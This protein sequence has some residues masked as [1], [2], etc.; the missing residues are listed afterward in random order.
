MAFYLEGMTYMALADKSASAD[1]LDKAIATFRS[2]AETAKSAE[3]KCRGLLGVAAVQVNQAWI[4]DN[5][6]DY[7]SAADT[8]EQVLRL[9]P[10]DSYLAAEAKLGLARVHVAQGNPEKA[11]PLYQEV[12]ALRPKPERPAPPPTDTADMQRRY[13]RQTVAMLLDRHSYA[14]LAQQELDNILPPSAAELGVEIPGAGAQATP[15]KDAA[16]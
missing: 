6:N 1:S 7:K 3:E 13:M 10:K 4:K 8:Y 15:V 5:P 14:E 11:I 16:K 12:I 2:Y 9:V